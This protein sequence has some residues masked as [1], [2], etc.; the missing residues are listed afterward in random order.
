MLP[1]R[2]IILTL[3]TTRLIDSS[4]FVIFT[5]KEFEFDE[6]QGYGICCSTDSHEQKCQC[7]MYVH[8]CV[9]V[10]FEHRKY[11]RDC[12]LLHHNSR[13]IADTRLLSNY[14]VSIPFDVRWPIKDDD[15][16]DDDDDDYFIG[17]NDNDGD[18]DDNDNDND[19][20]ADILMIND[21]I[22]NVSLL[23]EM[24][25]EP[26]KAVMFRSENFLQLSPSN[27]VLRITEEKG[28]TKIEYDIKV[29]CG[30]N[31]YGQECAIFCNPSIG[32]FHFKCSSDGQRLCEDGWSGQN[33]DD[34]ICANG[35]INGYCI[36]PGVC[37]CRN[38]WQGNNCDRCK[39]QIDCKHGYCNKPN[40]CICEKN[41]GGTYCDKD[42]DYC[43]HHSPCL[44]GGKCSS[45]GLQNYYYCNC[46][47][48]FT[49]Q[50]CQIKLDPCA[51]VNCGK[52]GRCISSWNS[53][54]KYLCYCDATHH[55]D[56]CQY[57][58]DENDQRHVNFHHSFQSGNCKLSNLEYMPAGF[59]WTTVDCRQCAIRCSEKRCE[60]RDCSHNDS[61]FENS[62][63][64]PNDQHCVI[65]T[66]DECLKGKC[67]YPRGRCLSWLQIN[68]ETTRRICRERLNAGNQNTEKCARIYLEFN[69]NNL[70]PGTTSDIITISDERYDNKDFLTNRIR[71][72]LTASPI[73][74]TIVQINDDD[75]YENRKHH[76]L[77]AI[78]TLRDSAISSTTDSTLLTTKQMLIIII[79]LMLL[80]ILILLNI[81]IM[82][83]PHLCTRKRCKDL[84]NNNNFLELHLK[85][86]TQKQNTSS[87]QSMY[88]TCDQPFLNESK[89]H[90]S[91]SEPLDSGIIDREL[92]ENEHN[93][94]ILE[95]Q[96]M[97]PKLQILHQSYSDNSILN[98]LPLQLTGN[99]AQLYT[100]KSYQY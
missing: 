42:L 63:I 4:G 73:L 76:I 37:R 3:S 69:L 56:H 20:F 60:P 24:R 25:H 9:G 40:E 28:D 87:S 97:K 74:A 84:R 11:H 79:C 6:T 46:T 19:D 77:D 59:S 100:A 12:S 47:N 50:N 88:E 18:D 5:L 89:H 27:D 31:Y 32:S 1:L 86:P 49:G 80:I 82:K 41:W 96:R 75:N 13:V 43:F 29:E 81:S 51:N 57:A 22:D 68:S 58:V 39:P 15:S 8:V 62:L 90:Y 26:S 35:C 70:L 16:E 7:Q 99:D 64:C 85:Q 93:T 52:Y 10:G 92:E 66:E 55:G 54:S 83:N 98:P 72:R 14:N 65:I 33:C 78:L 36:S 45:G 30:I 71:N 61:N 94:R 17:D 53:K 91:V 38:G 21:M 48:G 2:F 44:N 67:N 23:V 95:Q 34:P